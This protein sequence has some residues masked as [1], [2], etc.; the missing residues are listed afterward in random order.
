MTKIEV[1]EVPGRRQGQ[2]AVQTVVRTTARKINSDALAVWSLLVAALAL[3]IAII[4]LFLADLTADKLPAS[5][6]SCIRANYQG[7]LYVGVCK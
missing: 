2:R 5:G 4:A 7:Q 6:Q 3:L 1:Q